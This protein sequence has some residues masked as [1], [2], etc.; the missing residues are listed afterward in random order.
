MP[1]VKVGT[2]KA[3]AP[4][5]EKA[6]STELA[7]WRAAQKAR[8]H[9]GK[10]DPQPSVKALA[11][12]EA[13]V[14]KGQGQVP[15]HQISDVRVTDSLV[16]RVNYSTGNL[17]LAATDSQ[18][19]GA[20]QSLQLTR[21]YNS[22]EA[23]WGKIS[24][25]WWV[26]YERYLQIE[27]AKVTLYDATGGSVS[28]TKKADGTFTTPE[29]HRLDLKKE[30]NGEY[31]VTERGSGQKDT[32]SE[33]GTLLKTSDRNG[34]QIQVEQHDDGT[35]HKGF[36]LTDSRSGRWI[37]L[38]KTDASQWQAKDNVGRTI[39]YDLNASGDS[40]RPPTPRARPPASAT[41][42]TAA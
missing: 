14:P 6:P 27:T 12:V 34:G 1:P 26:N 29:G 21:T 33:A 25:R 2:A 15:W 17:M 36:K 13:L 10:K 8:A 37:D 23:P 41:T 19:T 11:A 5:A 32:Y 35:E 16:A 3:P 39:V 18:V 30:S 4:V 42:P 38:L 40:P 20:G 28:F 22:I 24:Q 9:A 31:T 7:Q